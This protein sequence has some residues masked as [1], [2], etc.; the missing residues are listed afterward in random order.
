LEYPGDVY[1]APVKVDTI[2][3]IASVSKV[4]GATTAAMILY[5]KSL[6]SL[7]EKVAFYLPGFGLN[8]KET[9]TIRNLLLHNSGLPA[10]APLFDKYWTRTQVIAWLYNCTLDYQTGTQTVYSD[11][12]MVAL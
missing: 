7:D 8:N 3:D 11:L 1:P 9:I 5:E 10:D 4:V 12:S 2:Y 6:L